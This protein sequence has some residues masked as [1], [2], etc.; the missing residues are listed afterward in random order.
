MK[1]LIFQIEKA[2][3]GGFTAQALGEN[4]F[5]EADSWVELRLAIK[6]AVVCHFGENLAPHSVRLHRVEEELLPIN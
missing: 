2:P 6:D 5:T 1:E 3:E 4:I